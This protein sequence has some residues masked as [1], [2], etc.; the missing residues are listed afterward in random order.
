[1]ELLHQSTSSSG[2]A[3]PDGIGSLVP[4]DLRALIGPWGVSRS[5]ITSLY[6][7]AVTPA[8]AVGGLG[9]GRRERAAPL[10]LI[11]LGGVWGPGLRR[12]A[13]GAVPAG[14]QPG[15]A[16]AGAR[17]GPGGALA[18]GARRPGLRAAGG[19]SEGLGGAGAVGADRHRRRPRRR[20]RAAL[21]RAAGGRR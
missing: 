10:V 2:V 7:G 20:A 8:L 13:P 19:P 14:Q 4:G 21:P 1:L 11:A 18:G 6:A 12:L 5:E 16:R 3:D 9:R 15:L 17:H